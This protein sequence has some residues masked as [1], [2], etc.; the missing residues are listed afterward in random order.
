MENKKKLENK[1]IEN[2]IDGKSGQAIKKLNNS[3]NP[4]KE[5][6]DQQEKNLLEKFSNK[7]SDDDNYDDYDYNDED[8]DYDDEYDDEF[9]DIMP[10][11]YHYHNS[12]EKCT[13]YKQQTRKRHLESEPKCVYLICGM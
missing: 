9:D 1:S 2:Q 7:P 12:C 4:L 13:K 3:K 10:A 8:Y 11:C 5:K 6:S